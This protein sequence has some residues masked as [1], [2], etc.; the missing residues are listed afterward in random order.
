MAFG[1]TTNCVATCTSTQFVGGSPKICMNC[2]SNCLTCITSATN[3]LTCGLSGG[4]QMYLTPTATCSLT[5]PSKYYPNI[6]TKTCL[7]CHSSCLTCSGPLSTDCLSCD[8][9]GGQ[10]LYF[11]LSSNTCILSCSQS[12][13]SSGIT[14]ICN[15]CD[16]GCLSCN[17]VSSNT[18]CTACNE[19]NGYN[20]AVGSTNNCI[21]G[22]PSG[23]FVSGNP[24]IC[25]SCDSNCATCVTSATNCLSCGL[26]GGLQM[27]LTPT[28]TC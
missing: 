3:C 8:V 13:Y 12:Y 14:H 24:K 1:S 21:R 2:D 7:G 17:A 23:Q 5:C 4:S 22:C 27:Y 18:A 25:S 16:T 28:A 11:D 20:L 26:S 15:Q 19:A 6:T 9:S 10:Q